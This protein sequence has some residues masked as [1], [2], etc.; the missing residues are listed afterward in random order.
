L[1]SN[2]PNAEEE[3][4]AFFTAGNSGFGA[5]SLNTKSLAVSGSSF[6]ESGKLR[7]EIGANLLQ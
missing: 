2:S 6:W 4:D 3:P 5:V 7:V 1:K